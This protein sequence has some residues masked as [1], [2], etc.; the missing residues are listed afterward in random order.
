[1]TLEDPVANDKYDNLNTLMTSGWFDWASDQIQAAL[2]T[3]A[4]F[5]KADVYLEDLVA[6][7]LGLA[8]VQGRLVA[9]DHSLLGLPVSF[10]SVDADIELQV[11][12]VRAE[13]SLHNTLL[14]WYD[15]DDQDNP[16]VLAN[17]GTFILRPPVY[18]VQGETAL[19]I[20]VQF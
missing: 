19:G 13:D 8:P 18:D 11:V 10:T 4:T 9:A 14:A 12:L 3:G 20:W 5:N 16:M 2:L 7:N 15:V 17:H 1:V 6:S